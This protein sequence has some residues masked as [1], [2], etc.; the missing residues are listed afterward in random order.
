MKTNH[1]SSEEKHKVDTKIL[2]TIL[3]TIAVL[4][5]LI[6]LVSTFMNLGILD[7]N[8]KLN[9]SKETENTNMQE[10][11]E[12]SY[13]MLSYID[14][15]KIN[16]LLNVYDYKG[17]NSINILNEN[18]LQ[19]IQCYGKEKVGI[20]IP[21]SKENCKVEITSS[22]GMKKTREF[23]GKSIKKYEYTGDVQTLTLPAGIYG[24]QLYGAAG[25]QGYGASGRKRWNGLWYIEPYRRYYLLFIYWK[26]RNLWRTSRI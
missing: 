9:M 26:I 7:K 4:L 2:K 25:G 14:D 6:I 23:K 10:K 24:L 19:T 1:K 15:N 18:Q 8:F 21:V 20:D 5:I 22:T 13:N 3:I 17:I 12:I 16:I 11:I